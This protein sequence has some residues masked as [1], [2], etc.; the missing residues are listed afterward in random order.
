MIQSS[1]EQGTHFRLFRQARRRRYQNTQSKFPTAPYQANRIHRK[2]T[3]KKT[4]RNNL[5]IYRILCGYGQHALPRKSK[6]RNKMTSTKKK[7]REEHYWCID[8]PLRATQL[9]RNSLCT[10]IQWPPPSL[11]VHH[12]TRVDK[13]I[14]T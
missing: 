14:T 2:T 3:E 8:K 9:L 12:Y 5:Q 10:S 13:I 6:V 11:I 4:F 7:R 1:V